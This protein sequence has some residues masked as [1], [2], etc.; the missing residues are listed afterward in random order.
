ML[1]S[2]HAIEPIQELKTRYLGS[3]NPRLHPEEVLIAL[4][5][6]AASDATAKLALDQIPKLAGCQAHVSVRPSSSDRA[7]MKTLGIVLTC[8]P[9]R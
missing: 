5:I 7:T 2:P 3:H 6:S 9:L 1:I 8:E 4:S